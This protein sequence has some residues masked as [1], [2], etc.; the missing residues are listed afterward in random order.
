MAKQKTKSRPGNT[1][2]GLTDKQKR[3]CD[4]YLCD[5]N[6]TQAA[7]RAGY[8]KRTAYRTGADNLKKPQIRAYIDKR[9]AEKDVELIATQNEVLQYLTSVMRGESV[10]VEVVVDGG[11]AKLI[12]KE[13]SEMERIK[14]ADQL[15]KCHGLYR[16]KD[17]MKIDLERLEIEQQR[18]EI[19][20]QK[21]DAAEPDKEIRVEIGGYEEGWSE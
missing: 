21:A 16:D 17:K 14:A 20:K 8:S 13:P 7:I 3:F 4:E 18:L 2:N 9:M 12:E 10:A 5:M 11:G 19:E 6:A 15:A 1:K